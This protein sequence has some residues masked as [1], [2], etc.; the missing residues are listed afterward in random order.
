MGFTFDD[1]KQV[2]LSGFKS[3][4]LPFHV[5][6]QYLRRVSDEL[7][8]FVHEQAEESSR[9]LHAAIAT[10]PIAATPPTSKSPST[11]PPAT[12]VQIMAKGKSG[13]PS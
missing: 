7:D 6:Q 1:L 8:A 3:A 10:S 4:F 11:P 13:Q 2:I 5:K 9:N 12:T